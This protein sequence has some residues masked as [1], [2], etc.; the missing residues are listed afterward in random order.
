MANQS[1]G[2]RSLHRSYAGYW[3]HT[4]R[5]DLD[6]D[7]H[8]DYI[9]FNP[10]KHGHAQPVQDWSHSSFHRCVRLGHYP[11]DWA[12]DWAAAGSVCGGTMMGAAALDPSCAGCCYYDELA[13]IA[14]ISPHLSGARSRT[15][16]VRSPA[17][18]NLT[19]Q[20]IVY[21]FD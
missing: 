19:R 11:I 21:T 14:R 8:A 10:V 13:K 12:G 2:F 16:G 4:V 7:S 1:D 3:E 5:D 17:T 9:H 15:R 6:F 18:K 20:T